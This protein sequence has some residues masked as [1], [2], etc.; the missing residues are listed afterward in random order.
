MAS[1]RLGAL[2]L[3]LALAGGASAGPALRAGTS[4][5]YPPFS[6]ALEDGGYAGFDIAVARAYAA[7]RR[8][9]L[10][11]VRFRWPELL[12]DL[13]GG[14]FDLALSGI[15]VRPERSAVGRFSVPVLETGAVLLVREPA[16]WSDLDA[17]DTPAAR[18]AVN[19]GGHLEQ[20][21]R[22]RLGRATLVAI[23]DNRAVLDALVGEAVDAVVTEQVEAAL[24]QAQVEGSK[25]LGPFSRDRKA[26][27]VR[28]DRG[29]L[30]ADLDA[31]LLA[32]DA[33]GTLAALR[34]EHL[35]GVSDEAVATPLGAL[36][37]AVDERLALMPTVGAAKR[38]QGF[39]LEVPERE[40]LVLDAAVA[41]V[42]AAARRARREPPPE[43]LVRA[44]FRAQIE[45]ARQVQ[46]SAVQDPDLALAPPLPDVDETLRPALLRIGQKIARLLLRLPEG[47]DDPALRRAARRA[48]RS[49]YLEPARVEA[50]ADA[51]GAL[52]RAPRPG[53]H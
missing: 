5:D 23:A 22:R 48:L 4:G 47:L 25:V 14:A 12:G 17:F 33:D 1:L 27:L 31:W 13:R 30:A 15:T 42:A 53:R 10:G 21:A 16:R 46:W 29:D 11:W 39:P 7:E 19:A 44:F 3:G 6:R 51:L 40:G 52:S 35:P 49:P 34:R 18:I 28:A 41:D 20:L 2:A 45:A 43:A 9:E 50:I 32:R 37:A 8:L 38:E 24:W 26:F 36:L